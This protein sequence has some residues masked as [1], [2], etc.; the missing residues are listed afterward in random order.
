MSL[1]VYRLM[2]ANCFN[3]SNVTYRI[4]DKK[5]SL[6]TAG[7][8]DSLKIVTMQI[9]DSFGLPNLLTAGA[10]R[11]DEVAFWNSDESTQIRR[12]D[13]IPDIVPG[14]NEVREVSLNQSVCP[15][16]NKL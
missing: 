14:L 6:K 1:T 5:P 3:H 16:L 7:Q 2:L 8:A 9:F 11:I 12:T 10:L 15:L 4:V 13:I